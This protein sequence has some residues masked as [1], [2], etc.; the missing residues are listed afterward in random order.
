M[1]K[2]KSKDILVFFPHA[3]LIGR[4]CHAYHIRQDLRGKVSELRVT[5]KKAAYGIPSTVYSVTFTS[6]DALRLTPFP[7]VKRLVS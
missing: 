2:D 5:A 1:E 6:V 3:V 4:R 7:F